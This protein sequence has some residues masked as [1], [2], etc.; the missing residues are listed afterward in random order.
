M[1]QVHNGTHSN[2]HNSESDRDRYKM[3]LIQIDI[4]VSLVKT[5]IKWDSFIQK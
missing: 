4:I 3:G 5:G 2:R 1:R